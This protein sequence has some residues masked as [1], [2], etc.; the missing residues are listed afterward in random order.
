MLL[1]QR[2]AIRRGEITDHAISYEL[3]YDQEFT[4]YLLSSAIILSGRVTEWFKEPVL[5]TG[6]GQPTE[7]SNPS[8]SAKNLWQITHRHYRH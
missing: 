2:G 5:K 4:S 8:P 3:A 7:G 6:V 1:V